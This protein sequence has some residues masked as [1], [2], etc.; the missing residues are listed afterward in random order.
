MG[1]LLPGFLLCRLGV[2]VVS[3][4]GGGGGGGEEE[5]E[6]EEEEVTAFAKARLDFVR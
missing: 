3:A 5:E 2:M 6:E 1:Y 4:E